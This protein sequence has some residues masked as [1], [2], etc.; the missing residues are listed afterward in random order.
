MGFGAHQLHENR[1]SVRDLRRNRGRRFLSGVNLDVRD[2]DLKPTLRE[3]ERNGTSET[4]IRK[5]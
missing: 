5:R 2:H 4:C 1:L 3:A